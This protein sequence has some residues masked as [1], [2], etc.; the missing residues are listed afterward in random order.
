MVKLVL[1]HS[2]RSVEAGIP[3]LRVG[4]RKKH[5][6]IHR[7]LGARGIQANMIVAGIK[8]RDFDND[9]STNRP[10]ESMPLS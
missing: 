7:I 6:F 5:G 3:T 1:L 2:T 9:E 4:T 10:H 8:D